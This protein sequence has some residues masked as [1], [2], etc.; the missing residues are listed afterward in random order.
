[1]QIKELYT[2]RQVRDENG[3]PTG[4]LESRLTVRIGDREVSAAVQVDASYWN[5]HTDKQGAYE[6]T[7]RDLRR[8]IEREVSRTAFA[9]LS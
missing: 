5:K 3:K 6:Y 4:M 1:M 8:G 2:F 7:V 9:P